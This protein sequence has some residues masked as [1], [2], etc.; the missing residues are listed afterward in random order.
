MVYDGG[1]ICGV[2]DFESRLCARLR[3]LYCRVWDLA[4][5]FQ[6]V[7]AVGGALVY[8]EVGARV[9]RCWDW[10]SSAVC[11]QGKA[12]EL[13]PVTSSAVD[14]VGRGLAGALGFLA[15]SNCCS[16]GFPES[17]SPGIDGEETAGVGGHLGHAVAELGLGRRR[18]RL[19]DVR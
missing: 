15:E 12:L 2:A 18:G 9:A 13:E 7:V 17:G 3:W 19:A 10:A 11:E 4:G 16:P 6:A 8:G 1:W 5:E 14:P